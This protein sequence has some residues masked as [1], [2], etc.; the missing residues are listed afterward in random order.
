[1]AL[2]LTVVVI[3][4]AVLVVAVQERERVPTA[5]LPTS[6]IRPLPAAPSARG[7]GPVLDALPIVEGSADAA[8]VQ[9]VERYAA[10]LPADPESAIAMVAA[11][12][13]PFAFGPVDELYTTLTYDQEVQNPRSEDELAALEDA[14]LAELRTDPQ[15]A[16]HLNA[17]AVG[18]FA[19]GIASQDGFDPVGQFAGRGY[20]RRVAYDLLALGL[21]AFP[22]DRALTLNLAALASASPEYVTGFEP[23]V[24]VIPMLDAF[25]RRHPDDVTARVLLAHLQSRGDAN[26]DLERA[27]ATLEPLAKTDQYA[28]LVPFA[29]GD[30]MI[31][32]AEARRT[33][34]P[35]LARR[36]ARQ[37]LDEYDAAAVESGLPDAYAGRALA[38]DILGDL[39]GAIEAQRAAVEINPASTV[40]WLRLAELQGCAGDQSGREESARRAIEAAE[41][42]PPRLGTSRLIMADYAAHVVVPDRGFGGYSLGSGT[43]ALG[44]IWPPPEGEGVV[45]DLDPFGTPPSCLTLDETEP[46]IGALEEGMLAALAQREA[47]TTKTLYDEHST[48]GPG[49]GVAA[50]LNSVAALLDAPSSDDDLVDALVATQKRLDPA[51]A[52]QLCD[53]I[54]RDGS[55]SNATFRT[56]DVGQKLGA[57]VAESAWR[58]GDEEAA[59]AA[60]QR[61]IADDDRGQVDGLRLLQAGMVAE[62]VG[63]NDEARAAYRRAAADSD[64]I[65]SALAHLGDLTLTE[66]DPA[67]AVALYDLVLAVVNQGAGQALLD[68]LSL[69]ELRAAVQRVRNNRSVAILMAAD[70]QSRSGVDCVA[71]PGPCERAQADV[72]AALESDPGSWIYQMNAGYVARLRGDDE[73]AE[74]YL[75]EA[76][77]GEPSTAW[78]IENDLGVLAAER[79]ALDEARDHLGAAIAVRPDYALAPWN[80]GVLEAASGPLGFLAGQG[81]LADAARLQSG[82]RSAPTAYRFDEA[83]FRIE[84]RRG[85]AAEVSEIPSPAGLA[86]AAFASVAAVGS[87]AR[88]GA[89]LVSPGREAAMTLTKRA[90]VGR[91][92]RFRSAE[93]LWLGARRL[94]IAWSSWFV[95]LPALVVLALGIVYG[96]FRSAPDAIVSG[97]LVGS[98]TVALALVTH[99]AGHRVVSV[100]TATR[101][102]PARWDAGLITGIGALIFQ[103]PTGPFPAEAIAGRDRRLVWIAALAGIVANCIAAGVAYALW[104]IEPLP[105]L[106]SL[107]ITQLMVAAYFLMPSKPLDGS[108]LEDRPLV[109]VGFGFAIAAASIALAIGVA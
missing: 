76:L 94:G 101:V 47:A 20:T 8:G 67:S 16:K 7:V 57:C 5:A 35:L 84:L 44:V 82:F 43:P 69:P 2:V 108:R 98:V 107:V 15:H 14:A 75:Q 22:D 85:Q 53:A 63:A 55:F 109:T 68:P 62:A 93:R 104:W 31:A 46:Q 73:A 97:L 66:G 29:R 45:I 9:I 65:V 42:L 71:D 17:L 87:L 40:W 58:N 33:E 54:L 80:R 18:L 89:A 26:D 88:L 24:E 19:L 4:A 78:A 95:W 37:A 105:V 100:A 59:H 72:E 70:A 86:A 102:R 50:D 25:V 30:S 96:A 56:F 48:G 83:V 12:W 6:D 99:Q 11:G 103:S 36:L 92:R 38:L 49:E 52:G 13:A 106:R 23:R 39:D 1:M 91:K 3:P 60:M 10:L 28:A 61:V 64:T 41:A 27:L 32:H 77:T 79:G 81:W 74:R 34:S 21:E 90:L 51:L